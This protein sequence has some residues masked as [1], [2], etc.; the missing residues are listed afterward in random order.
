[1]TDATLSKVGIGDPSRKI[2]R[3]ERDEAMLERLAPSVGAWLLVQL[4]VIRRVE[5]WLLENE[6]LVHGPLHSSIGQEAVA[7]GTTAALRPGDVITSTH[8]A[9]HHVLSKTMSHYAGH[10]FDPRNDVVPPAVEDCVTRTLAEILG[11]ENGWAGGR[12]GSMHL[13]D[14]ESGVAGTSAIVGGGIPIAAGLAYAQRLSEPAGVAVS[15]AGDGAASIGA[16]HEGLSM[17]RVWNLPAIFVIEN[18]LY[19]VATTVEETVG[20]KDI[21]LR[22]AGHDMM[23]IIVDGMDPIAVYEATRLARAHASSGA[24]PVLIEAKT[25]RYRHQ[26]GKLPGSAYR[27]RTKDEEALWA[28][29]DPLVTFARDLEERSVLTAAEIGQLRTVAAR[30]TAGAADAC[31]DTHDGKVTVRL[32]RLPDPGTSELG[33]RGD[34][35]EFEDLNATLDI[36]SGPTETITFASAISIAQARALE[37]DPRVFILGEEVSH[38]G[39]GAYGSTKEALRADPSRVLSTPIAENGFCGLALGAALAGLRPIIEVMFPD[40]ALEAADQLFNHIAKARHVYGGRLPIPIVLRTRT[41]QGR[42]F[43]PQ[44]STDPAALFAL[45]PGWRIAAPSNSAEYI[46]V[47]NAALRCDDPVLVIEHHALWP[48]ASEVPAGDFEYVLPPGTG[49]VAREGESAT[50]LAWSHPLHRVEL[51]ADELAADG[52]DIEIIDPR[53]LD[54]ASLDRDLIVRSVGKTGVLVIVED[55]PRSHSV[56]PQIVDELSSEIT[57]LLRKPVTRITGKDVFPPVSRVLEEDVLL[58]DDVIRAGLRQAAS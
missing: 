53:W 18:N 2:T 26:N 28:Q 29:R 8:R 5:E 36:E 35:S 46:G 11:L 55:A 25:Y 15:F 23:G 6:E 48:H 17:A 30:L 50:V 40:F 37:R 57:S 19:S 51:I 7:V 42:G 22:A 20:F 56:G 32:D 39:G 21:A 3:V 45:F 38:L 58:A 44:H 12:G 43:G 49:R 54:R 14:L 31:T 47:F 16:F 52:L 1:M 10:N 34:L 13:I 27:Y 33:V 24:G 9:H 4:E 41:A